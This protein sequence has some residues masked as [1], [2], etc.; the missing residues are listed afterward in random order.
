MMDMEVGVAGVER[1]GY[2]LFPRASY[3]RAEG[4]GL[5]VIRHSFCEVRVRHSFCEVKVRVRHTAI[6][7]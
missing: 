4:C 6:R 7:Y 5:E 1:C 2:S 3:V